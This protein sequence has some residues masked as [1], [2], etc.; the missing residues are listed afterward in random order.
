MPR[1]LLERRC[2]R[3]ALGGPPPKASRSSGGS[4]AKRWNRLPRRVTGRLVG[5]A[6]KRAPP[7][8]VAP[9]GRRGAAR[10]LCR[11][12]GSVFAR[13]SVVPELRL[14]AD[15]LPRLEKGDRAWEVPARGRPGLR[16]DW[17][18]AGR[19]ATRPRPGHFLT[20]AA[21]LVD[22]VLDS[23]PFA[24]SATPDPALTSTHG[25]Q[26]RGG[27]RAGGIDADFSPPSA[28]CVGRSTRVWYV[29]PEPS[30]VNGRR[31]SLL[32]VSSSTFG[33]RSSRGGRRN[34]FSRK[35]TYPQS[36]GGARRNRR[37]VLSRAAG[38]ALHRDDTDR[39][40]ERVQSA[41]LAP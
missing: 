29:R 27:L 19:G 28:C 25:R 11:N 5:L 6:G 23:G 15:H 1:A 2:G 34:G 22:G 13:R 32:G 36:R 4:S 3:L 40:D 7:R 10:A 12:C 9:E 38:G 20:N 39:E 14:R 24:A 18:S 26:V 17:E 35:A 8:Q 21:L 33:E 16:C 41:S 31:P 30:A 37:V